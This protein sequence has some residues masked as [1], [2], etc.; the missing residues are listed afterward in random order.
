MNN[1]SPGLFGRSFGEV[2]MDYIHGI[3]RFIAPIFHIIA[4]IIII[5]VIIQGG[6]KARIFTIYFIINYLW[7]FIFVGLYISFLL[8]QKMG[9][10]FLFFWGPV[11]FLLFYILLN[12]INELK[13]PNNNL[14]FDNIPLY[15]FVVLPVIL[16]GFWYPAYIWNFGFTFSYKDLLFSSFGLMPCP[17]TMVVLGLLTL[18]YPDV[19]KRLFYSLTLFSVM[20]GSAQIAIKYVPDYPLAFLGYYSLFLI[21]LDRINKNKKSSA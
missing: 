16:F 1:F 8:F 6:K 14:D 19:N 10:T 2:T 9:I 21:I 3:G 15:R 11:P 12:W 18:K 20:V 4:L 17:T 7:L 5:L 13:S